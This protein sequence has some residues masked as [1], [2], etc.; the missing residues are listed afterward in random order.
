[1]IQAYAAVRMGIFSISLVF[2]ASTSF[3]DFTAG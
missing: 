2:I 1:M 3:V